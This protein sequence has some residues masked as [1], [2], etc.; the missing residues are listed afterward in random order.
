[1]QF[2]LMPDDAH[3]SDP[4]RGRGKSGVALIARA[5]VAPYGN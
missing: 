3:V 1:M 2:P 5:L 4:S